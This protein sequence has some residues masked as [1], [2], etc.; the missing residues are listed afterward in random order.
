[1]PTDAIIKS[2]PVAQY[3]EIP[4]SPSYSY[5]ERVTK[6]HTYQG[7]YA[8]VA[9]EVKS[10][11]TVGTGEHAGWVVERCGYTRMPKGL[12]EVVV[13]WVAA[14]SLY[15]S[16]P[17]ETATLTPIP[18]NP[19]LERHWRY[20]ALTDEQRTAIRDAL[21][22]SDT[23]LRTSN[24]AKI[25]GVTLAEELLAKLRQ[26]FENFYLSGLKYEWKSYSWAAPAVNLGGYLESP[27]GPLGGILP[28]S[29]S[30]LR[31]ADGIES[32]TNDGYYTKTLTWTGGPDG[33]WDIDIYS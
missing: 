16:L 28:G 27:A 11:W 2:G 18:V 15:G 3:V 14:G 30:W 21:N 17:I 8:A 1:M 29:M 7:V 5:D 19:K 13:E 4:T 9:A 24:E 6:V 25:S 22:S 12:G 20:G 26:G 23:G 31:E 32:P 33:F 10:K